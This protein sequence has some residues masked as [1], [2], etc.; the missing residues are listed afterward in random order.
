MGPSTKLIAARVPAGVADI[1]DA[2]AFVRRQSMQK[3]VAPA[4]E[5]LAQDLA[6]DP[7]VEAALKVRREADSRA[8][9]R[10]TSITSQKNSRR[11]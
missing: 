6:K 7:A 5:A 9:G 1:L 11:K 8:G 10:V 3:L 4:V 2:A